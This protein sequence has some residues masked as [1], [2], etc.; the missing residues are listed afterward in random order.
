[1]ICNSLECDKR[2]TKTTKIMPAIAKPIANMR[3]ADS[4]RDMLGD[5]F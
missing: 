2:P 3:K 1:M 5:F 4:G